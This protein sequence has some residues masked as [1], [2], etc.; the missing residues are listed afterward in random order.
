[1]E[2]DENRIAVNSL[3]EY[4]RNAR[5]SSQIFT[6]IW[7]EVTT[8]QSRAKIY[9]MFGGLA[10]MMVLQTIQPAAIALIFNG[11]VS[12]HKTQIYW[13]IGTFF[14]CIFMQKLAECYTESAREWIIGLHMGRQDDRITELFFEKS[15]GQHIQ[16]GSNLSVSSIDKGRWQLLE[17]QGL[18]LFEGIPTIAQLT[19]A[20]ICLCCLNVVAGL[21][22][23]FVI[24]VYIAWSMYLNLRVNQVCTPID[25]DFRALNRR[26]V[27][28]WEKVERVKVAGKEC[29]ETSEMSGLF[30]GIIER[31]RKFWLWFI[32]NANLRSLI[33][34]TGL[35]SIMAWGAHLVWT[36]VWQ[37]GFLYPL[38]TWS[39]RVSEN[40]WR[41]GSIERQINWN[42][43]SVKSMIEALK[44]KPTIID[45]SEAISIDPSKPHHVEFVNV[46]HTYPVEKKDLTEAPPTLT[47]VNFSI[48]PGEKVALLGPSGAGKTT[49]MR[50][51]LR[52]DDPTS[53]KIV[54][55]GLDLKTISQASWRSGIG[56]VPQQSQVFDGTIRSNLTYRLTP[57]EKAEISDE[58]LWELMRL[59]QID[60]KDRLT[61]GLDTVVGKNGI[62]LSGGQAQ[63]LMIG[64]SVIKRPWLLI[65]DEATSSLDSITEH[66]VQEG[67][68]QILSGNTTSALI[69]AH[70]LSTVRHLCTQFVVLKA[71]SD[72]RNGDS[73]VE[74]IAPSFEEL[75]QISPT[76]RRLAD[77][78]GV[79]IG[80]SK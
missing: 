28:R 19:I 32:R 74:A 52:F 48:A 21:I 43:P 59:L 71:A 58:K 66:E 51:L 5:N 10:F 49:V 29:H 76:F 44:I 18:M 20:Y 40:I 46:S 22:M 68:T 75:Y 42:M 65:V 61:E 53:G 31:D 38:Y 77:Y 2:D 26:R 35:I 62:K 7:R 79:V 27:E 50:K 15:I 67:L 34:A 6:W 36:N 72:V 30:D 25:K 55:D 57:K 11:L 14:T 33:N 12:N 54:I 13:G 69:V 9:R 41:I 37:I 60:F 23:G 8:K 24:A 78:Q 16:E 45:S 1:M 4:L 64:S 80:K 73:Q 3:G 17:M 39:T 56:Y 47:R 70:R 63:R